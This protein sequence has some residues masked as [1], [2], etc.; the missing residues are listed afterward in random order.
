MTGKDLVLTIIKYNLLDVNIDQNIADLF[1][2][3]DEAAVKMGISTT[4]LHDMIKLGIVDCI[5]FG[6]KTYI[7]KDTTLTKR[8]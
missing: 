4:S 6:D 8:R 7:H 5:K 3:I 1:L 2:T